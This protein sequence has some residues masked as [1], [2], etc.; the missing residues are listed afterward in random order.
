MYRL[1]IVMHITV[2]MYA[3]NTYIYIYHHELP[4]DAWV[5][6]M[7]VRHE[8]HVPVRCSCLHID[9][10]CFAQLYP[11]KR[12][13]NEQSEQKDNMYICIYVYMYYVYMYIHICHI[14][15]LYIYIYM[16]H[17]HMS[18]IYMSHKYIVYI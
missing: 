4:T 13:R 9:Y 15:I 1:Y 12:K 3:Y 8:Y 2:N 5:I 18:Y 14:N 10:F 16:S 7:P 17:I 6:P 11:Q